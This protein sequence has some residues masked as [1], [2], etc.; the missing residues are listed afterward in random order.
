M[1]VHRL[2]S[3]AYLFDAIRAGRKLADIRRT[4]ATTASAIGWCCS[5]TT[6]STVPVPARN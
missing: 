1:S 3:W 2:K 6:T 4:T 5:A